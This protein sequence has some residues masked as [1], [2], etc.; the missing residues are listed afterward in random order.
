MA[1]VSACSLLPALGHG[2]PPPSEM[3]DYHVPSHPVSAAHDPAGRAV[4]LGSHGRH[5]PAPLQGFA[6]SGTA[7]WKS[8]THRRDRGVTAD[9]PTGSSPRHLVRPS[10]YRA[11]RGRG[12]R[13]TAKGGMGQQ[14][15]AAGGAGPSGAVVDTG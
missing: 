1:L 11:C 13:Q 6:V 7:W 4:S 14:G 15:A 9:H 5:L 2:G 3:I 8:S 12:H 10:V